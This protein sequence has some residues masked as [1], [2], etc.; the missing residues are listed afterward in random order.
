MSN[1][2]PSNLLSSSVDTPASPNSTLNGMT[3]SN[4]PTP[5]PVHPDTGPDP[6]R[7]VV[8]LLLSG[9]VLG[10][11]S[12]FVAAQMLGN[13]VLLEVAITFGIAAGILIGIAVTRIMRSHSVRCRR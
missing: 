6:Y 2:L 7:A 8:L 13:P 4:V 12:A 1:I 3:H 5:P 10:I 11:V 9:S